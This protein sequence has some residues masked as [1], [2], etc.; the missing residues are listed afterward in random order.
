MTGPPDRRARAWLVVSVLA[1]AGALLLAA[2]PASAWVAQGRERARLASDVSDLAQQNRRLEAQAALLRTDGEIERLARQD[3]GLVRPG[4]EAFAIIPPEAPP[5][6]LRDA[7][8]PAAPP[9]RPVARPWWQR[10]VSRL[11]DI[12]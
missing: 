1:L 5:A 2:F 3:Y 8:S 6:N 11:T 4:E 7:V 9:P 12:F 10:A